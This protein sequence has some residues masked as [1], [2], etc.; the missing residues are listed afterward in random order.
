MGNGPLGA[1]SRHIL[2]VIGAPWSLLTSACQRCGA[3]RR[4]NNRYWAAAVVD[5]TQANDAGSTSSLGKWVDEKVNAAST[6][7]DFFNSR[8]SGFL[9]ARRACVAPRTAA[10]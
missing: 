9:F 8:V 4:L 5:A 7:A 10:Q 2:V 1:V 3:P 6:C